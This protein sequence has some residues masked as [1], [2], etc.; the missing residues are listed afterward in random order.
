MMRC[1]PERSGIANYGLTPNGVRSGGR[2]FVRCP[3]DGIV[4]VLAALVLAGCT[5]SE[6]PRYAPNLNEWPVPS[7]PNGGGYYAPV[8]PRTVARPPFAPPHRDEDKQPPRAAPSPAWSA[9]VSHEAVTARAPAA[10]P[11]ASSSP[12]GDTGIPSFGTPLT[13][14]ADATECTGYWRICHFY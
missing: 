11:S 12:S 1:Y 7:Y 10:P 3:R 9:P 14:P 6:P 5:G 13:P 2:W 8:P 4:P